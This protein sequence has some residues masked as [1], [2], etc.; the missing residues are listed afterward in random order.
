MGPLVLLTIMIFGLVILGIIVAFSP[1]LIFTEVT[2]LT[3]SKRPFIDTVALISGI[4]V[5]IVVYGA[6]AFLFVDQATGFQNPFTHS[7]IASLPIVDVLAGLLLLGAGLRLHRP[8]RIRRREVEAAAPK[9]LLDTRALFIFG[10]IKMA[11]SF[12]SIAAI[13]IGVQ[14]IESY[15]RHGALQAVALLCFLLISIFPFLLIASLQAYSPETFA[16]V[17]SSSDRVARLDW[18][19]ILSWVFLLAG[20][21]F[22]VIGVLSI[23]R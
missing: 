20:A 10:L 6:L 5:P 9:K 19:M 1:T 4:M 23:T 18:I 2:V 11:T 21:Y 22:M 7:S 3:Q 14:F 16:R 12:S 17:K 8:R 15:I 13:M